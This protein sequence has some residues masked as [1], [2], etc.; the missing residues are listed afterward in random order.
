MREPIDIRTRRPVAADQPR[1]P[2]ADPSEPRPVLTRS[3]LDAR[4]MDTRKR[5]HR[6]LA[7]LDPEILAAALSGESRSQARELI[8]EVRTWLDAFE[9]DLRRGRGLQAIDSHGGF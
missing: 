6:D 5:I 4:F 1:P 8:G 3:H 2:A 7:T 9:H